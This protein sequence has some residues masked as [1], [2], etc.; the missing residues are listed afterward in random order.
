MWK[1]RRI[2]SLVV[3]IIVYPSLFLFDSCKG[4]TPREPV[5]VRV[6][7]YNHTQGPLGEKT[8]DGLS[9][10]NFT[11]AINSLGYSGIDPNRIVVRKSASREVMGTLIRFTKS[12]TISLEYPGTDETW[13]AY[14][15]NGGADYQLIDDRS[16]ALAT[17]TIYWQRKDWNA[18]GPDEPIIE[19]FNQ[20][21]G[22]LNYTWKQ[23]G[24]FINGD[25]GA[26]IEIGYDV[27]DWD[28]LESW[29]TFPERT[30]RVD[31]VKCPSYEIKLKFFIQNIFKVST[32]VFGL[33]GTGPAYIYVHETICNQQTGNLNQAGINL[34]A[35]VYLRD[36]Q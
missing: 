2:W 24:T 25:L 34:L 19:A 27:I 30:I 18:T 33:G 12:G 28:V 21:N 6:L 5:S 10:E 13:E 14:L 16:F 36:A 32:R 29:F 20:I 23:Y 4:G 1:Y 35:Y 7:F 26:K 9:G 22:A 8:Y 11:I 15:M 17:R 31:P 3:T